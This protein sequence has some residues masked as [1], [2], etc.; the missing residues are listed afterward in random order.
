MIWD[1]VSG[2]YDFT[3][4]IYNGKVYQNLGK[5][6]AAQIKQGDLVLECA[7]GTGAISK[8]I[9]PK[10]RHLTATDFPEGCCARPPKTVE[11][12]RISTI[13]RAT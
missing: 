3:E 4:T 13:R 1:N 7:C 2:I 6:V 8:C 5:A 10:C 12:M 11:V 9:A